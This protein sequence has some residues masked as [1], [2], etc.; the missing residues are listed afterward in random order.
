MV[1]RKLPQN[2][3]LII[4]GYGGRNSS[5]QRKGCACEHE[6]RSANVRQP[7]KKALPLTSSLFRVVKR[8]L[9]DTRQ[10]QVPLQTGYVGFPVRDRADSPLNEAGKGSPTCSGYPPDFAL[11]PD[12]YRGTSQCLAS[13]RSPNSAKSAASGE[14]LSHDHVGATSSLRLVLRFRP[15]ADEGCRFAPGKK[16]PAVPRL[17]SPTRRRFRPPPGA[18]RNSKTRPLLLPPGD[19][20][21]LRPS[22]RCASGPTEGRPSPLS[23]GCLWYT[24]K[25][26]LTSQSVSTTPRA[27]F[28]RRMSAVRILASLSDRGT[29]PPADSGLTSAP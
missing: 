13:G 23:Q 5:S 3:I 10:G 16:R 4:Q 21:F 22:R 11:F 6:S 24:E 1:G 28:S 14:G 15:E 8:R 20:V 25:R 19:S 17:P 2:N 12:G 7:R 18:L 26:P 29:L 27:R 9:C